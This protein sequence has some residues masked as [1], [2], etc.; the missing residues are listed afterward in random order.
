M[1]NTNDVDMIDVVRK[2][3]QQLA[4]LDTCDWLIDKIKNLEDP[5]VTTLSSEVY[6][7]INHASS[8]IA[9]LLK[10][11]ESSKIYRDILKKYRVKDDI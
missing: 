1:N 9:V 2:L 11:L 3:R 10:H 5:V 4:I 8:T 6:A 7:R